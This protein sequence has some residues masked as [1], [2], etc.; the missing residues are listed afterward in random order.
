MGT[1]VDI[2][3]TCT[4]LATTAGVADVDLD[5][6]AAAGAAAVARATVAP[7]PKKTKK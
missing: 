1:C 5:A 3:L 4:Y 2:G 7:Q 6:A